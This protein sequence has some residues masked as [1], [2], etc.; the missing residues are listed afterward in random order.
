[1]R[2]RGS[3]VN[4]AIYLRKSRADVEAERSGSALDTLQRHRATLLSLAASR[5]Y[6]IAQ[7]YEEIVSGDTIVDR[8]E[9][10]RLLHAVEQRQYDGVLCMDVDR[11]GRGDSI[12]QGII[13]KTFK[14]SGTRIITPDKTYD[15]RNEQD[16]LFFEM[17]QQFARIE[18]KAIKKRMW[19]GRMSSAQEG[20]WQSR[21]PFGYIKIKL[22][23][24]K[25]WSLSPDPQTADAARSIFALYGASG[26]GKQRIA[27]QINAMGY[28]TASGK[29]FTTSSIDSIL[30][31]PA[32]LGQVRWCQ[33]RTQLSMQNGVE[34]KSRPRSEECIIVSGRHPALITQ[35]QWDAVQS[36]LAS[37]PESKKK[38]GTPLRNP[39]SGLMVCAICGKAMIRTPEYQRP[40]E[41]VYRCSTPRCPTSRIDACHV[42]ASVYAALR[43]W[44]RECDRPLA[45]EA[46]ME[47]PANAQIKAVTAQ[48]AQ[49]QE[50]LDRQRDLLER[51]VYSDTVYLDRSRKIT[52]QLAAAQ[53]VLHTLQEKASQPTDLE[54]I[55]ALKEQIN[56]VLDAWDYSDPQQKN[57]LLRACVR[58][59]IY[60]KTER[61]YRNDSPADFL[62]LDVLPVLSKK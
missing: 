9:M 28:R 7:V 24:E 4:Y 35:E 52:E 34:V 20:K 3:P 32:Y 54:A 48:I 15:P 39:Y 61:C 16:E 8:P 41:A 10:Q 47:N 25:G 59:I 5:E 44:Q 55:H 27:A 42:D 6:A 22:P 51:G 50:Q 13:L 30:R 33:R 12:D 56:A 31:N 46:V 37:H 17:K 36:R 40:V 23:G 45:P 58:Q 18:Y 60:H 43:S 21:A 11:L 26:L 2:K 49:L 62:S 38:A 53:D 14:Y 1:M 29:P 19:L 57:A